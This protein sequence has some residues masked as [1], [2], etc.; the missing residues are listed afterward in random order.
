MS[1][2]TPDRESRLPRFSLDRRI[3][4]LVMLV[5]ILVLGAVATIGIPLELFPS[6]FNPPH[7]QV[8]VPWRDAPAQE[9]LDKII[10]PLEEELSTVGGVDN[11]FSYARTGYGQLLRQTQSGESFG[12]QAVLVEERNNSHQI[13]RIGH[14]NAPTESS[15]TLSPVRSWTRPRDL[16]SR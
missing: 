15:L 9:V 8:R 12:P 11:L 10:L 13:Y 6:G 14:W 4:V 1:A 5:T 3:T 16:P 2:Q 7:L